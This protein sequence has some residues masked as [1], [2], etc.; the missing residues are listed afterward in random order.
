LSSLEQ[1]IVVGIADL[2]V[3]NN[4]AVTLAT[5]ALGSCLGVAIYDPIARV[6]G[7]LHLMLPD[8]NLDAAKATK[9]P[10]MFVDTGVPGLF[11]TA[12]KL[13]A[14]KHRLIISVAGGADIMDGSGLFNLGTRNYEA[15]ARLFAGHGLRIHAEQVGGLV[16]RSM[17]L[18]LATGEVRLKISGQTDDTLVLC[19][20]STTT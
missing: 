7:L 1:I 3:S 18:I 13:G 19:K 20:N 16:N 10:G 14:E 5:Y 11:R 2:A 4:P 12:Y 15:L 8:S 6:G 17:R 9:Q